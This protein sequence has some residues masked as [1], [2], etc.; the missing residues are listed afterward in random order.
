MEYEFNILYYINIYKKWWKKIATVVVVSVAVVFIFS[1]IRP[2][3]YVSRVSLLSSAD[4]GSSSV[5][6]L[7]KLL[8]L[9][10]GSSSSDAIVAL[11]KSRRMVKD[12]NEEFN[13]KEKPNFRY[14][15]ENKEMLGG[16]II[17][18][19]GSDPVLT[20]EIADFTVKNLDK[21]NSELK[22][23]TAKPM[24]KVLDEA[25]KGVPKKRNILQKIGVMALLAVLLM[26]FYAFF[27]DYLK[28]LKQK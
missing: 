21:I 16:M 19:T 15:I 17:E 1:A 20:K 18:V 9:Q 4:T 5:S 14:S 25:V 26:S 2:V 24:V 7:G 6:S 28:K 10:A 22:I 3:D 12:I 27:S 8:G 13:L 11:L 23:T